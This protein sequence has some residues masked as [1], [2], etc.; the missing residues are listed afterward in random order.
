MRL[1]ALL[2]LISCAFAT[3]ALANTIT[4]K[5]V[6]VADGDTLTILDVARVQHKV[7]LAQIDAPETSHGKNK[8]GQPFGNDSKQS[9]AQLTFGKMVTASCGDTDRYGRSVCGISVCG[10]SVDGID[11]NREQVQRGMAWVY[12]RYAHDTTLYRA[13][14]DAKREKRGLWRLED[15]VPPWEWRKRKVKP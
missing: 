12:R 13:E 8:P 7:R 2:L 1:P 3:S 4:G 14:D 6:S 10:I 5:V 9:L 15:A 11:V